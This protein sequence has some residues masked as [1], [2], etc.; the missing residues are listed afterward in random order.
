LLNDKFPQYNAILNKEG[1]VAAKVDRN[2]FVRT[3][4]RSACL[5][6]GQFL[7]TTFVFE[8]ETVGVSLV[9]KEVGAF[10]DRIALT[11]Y[12]GDM[13]QIRFYAP[14]LLG[15]LQNFNESELQFYLH[16]FAKPIIFESSEDNVLFSYLVMPVSPSNNV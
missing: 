8:D 14:Y 3:I 16:N 7:P 2:S 9:N 11:G 5:L 1:F 6:S 13:M 12:Q 15:G 4:R 10:N